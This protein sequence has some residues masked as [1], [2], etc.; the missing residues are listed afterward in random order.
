MQPGDDQKN[1]WQ[2]PRATAP[3]AP[4]QPV[5]SDDAAAPLDDTRYTATPTAEDPNNYDDQQVGNSGQF[6]ESEDD[7]ALIRWQAT[8]Y[9][10]HDRTSTWYVAMVIV[11]LV[12]MA[13]AIFWMKSPT[14]AILI[15]VMAV[16][17][18]VY[19]RRPPAVIDYILSRKGLHVNDNLYPYSQYKSFSVLTHAG[20]HS[21]V[22]VPRKRFQ[23][24]Q[25]VYFPEEVGE[26]VVDMFAARLPMKELTPDLF[27]RLLARLR[28]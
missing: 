9:I 3:Q 7:Q 11:A 27:D 4:Y 12:L 19:V 8:E 26:V 1:E 22:L 15:P 14:F 21:I 6:E 23:V 2:Q 5:D 25:T 13:V 28:I 24:A 16:A 18:V 20:H 17:L 10:Q